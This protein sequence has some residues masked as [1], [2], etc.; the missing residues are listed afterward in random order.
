MGEREPRVTLIELGLILGSV[1]V[2]PFGGPLGFGCALGGSAVVARAIRRHRCNRSGV[3]PRA[4][5][6][7]LRR[8]NIPDSFLLSEVGAYVLIEALD[9]VRYRA[10][11]AATMADEKS[12]IATLCL[13]GELAEVERQLLPW[14]VVPHPLFAGFAG[15]GVVNRTPITLFQP[16]EGV[17]LEDAL[18]LPEDQLRP[19][20]GTLFEALEACAE[21]G[22]PLDGLGAGRLMLLGPRLM[23]RWKEPFDGNRCRPG[24]SFDEFEVAPEQVTAARSPHT[25]Q[26][27]LGVLLYQALTGRHPFNDGRD[28]ISALFAI[29][30]ETPAP[31]ELG[32][33]A[34]EAVVMRLLA[35][36]PD[37]R[38]PDLA[39]GRSA[40]LAATA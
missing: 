10:V 13:H 19:L 16:L 4:R 11:P 31:L 20:F 14:T 38:F 2:L 7:E 15:V 29:L 40:F 1:A 21:R 37:E 26:F 23:F 34:L 35:K 17:C 32:K 22:L 36:D 3:D 39:A 30:S 8:R 28:A 24:P 27:H 12:V 25:M 33:P 6:E 9:H 18:P 5:L